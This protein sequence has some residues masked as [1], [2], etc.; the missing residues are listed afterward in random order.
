LN[1]KI[2]AG[3]AQID[4]GSGPRF[5]SEGLTITLE[6]S[7][8]RL[9]RSKL[10]LYYERLPGGGNSLFRSKKLEEELQDLKVFIGVYG[11]EEKIPYSD[12]L[13]FSLN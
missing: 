3:L 12:A 6:K 8:P 4:D 2:G 1:F 13:P 9:V 7:R 5:G 10:G 11:S